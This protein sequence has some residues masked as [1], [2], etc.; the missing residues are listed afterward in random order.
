[1]NSKKP[2]FVNL[3][4]AR[5]KEQKSVMQRI[6]KQKICPFCTE[7]F[8]KFHKEPIL[9]DTKSWVLTT[10][11]WPYKNTKIHLLVIHKKH[12]ERVEEMDKTAGEELIGLIQWAEKEYSIRGG[13][14]A[15]RFGD[16]RV[17]GGTI[18][19]LHVQIASA[20]ITESDDPGYKKVKF[21]IG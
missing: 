3:D 7:N 6:L 20:K 18:A 8:R 13:G 1:M 2:N 21:R 19:H 14:V 15:M 11:Q 9:K 10:N 17:N 5:L 16:I 4:N 12:I